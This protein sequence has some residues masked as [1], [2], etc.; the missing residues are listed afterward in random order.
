MPLVTAEKSLDICK[1][2][3]RLNLVAIFLLCFLFFSFV[4]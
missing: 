1:K 3:K 2:Q 4:F